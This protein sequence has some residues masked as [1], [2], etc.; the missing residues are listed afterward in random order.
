M[1]HFAKLDANNVVIE[2]HVVN[3]E[4]CQDADGNESESVGIAYLQNVFG[5][6]TIWKQTS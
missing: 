2:I 3:N 1:A 6:D 4:D 5:S